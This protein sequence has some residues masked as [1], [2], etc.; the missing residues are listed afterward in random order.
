MQEAEK[1][2]KALKERI[3]KERN[4]PCFT[5]ENASYVYMEGQIVGLELTISIVNEL[6]K[7]K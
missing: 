2:I 7:N 6:I 5:T 1:I 4:H 3:K